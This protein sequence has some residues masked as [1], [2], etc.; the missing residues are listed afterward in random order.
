[1]GFVL[2]LL[3][4]L[5]SGVLG[6]LR[7]K[8]NYWQ[9]N[10]MKQLRA[11]FLF[12]HFVKL[13][14]LHLSELLQET[15]E[16]F[17]GSALLA[18]SYIYLRPIAVVLDLDL[19]KRILIEDC[20]K[21]VDRQNS[22]NE[23]L[24]DNLFNAQGE[25]WSKLRK[26]QAQI[27]TSGMMR[28]NMFE[29][30][31]KSANNLEERFRELVSPHGCVLDVQE[32]L[33]CY[34]MDA[35]AKCAFGSHINSLRD[36]Q[37]EFRVQAQK[38]L[39]NS[40][41]N[42]RWRL[43]KLYY[44]SILAKLKLPIQSH[45]KN[46]TE[47]FRRIVKEQME[48]RQL[49]NIKRNDYLELLVGNDLTLEQLT[50]QTFELFVSG[51]ETSSSILTCALFELAKHPAVQQKL[52]KE[53]TIILRKH[54][55][56]TYEAMLEMRY[57]EQTITET[58]RKYPALASLIRITAEEYT[59]PSAP[60]DIPLILD[61]DTIVH[62]PVHAIH[63][64]AEIYP[65]PKLFRPERFDVSNCLQRH[66]MAFLGF[67]AGPRQ[68]IGQHFGRLLIKIGLIQLLAQYQFSCVPGFPD[69]LPINKGNMILRPSQGVPLKVMRLS[70]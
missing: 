6:Y 24:T 38:I 21:F 40:D 3:T 14:S 43:F 36:D 28:K 29:T 51:Y 64:D 60:G 52:R 49:G 19:A 9:I 50:S 32:L 53:L 61:K 35:S 7:C 39:R 69:E 26:L 54:G 2:I 5:L 65:Q 68:C 31:T 25:E 46:I 37:L 20:D 16:A 23:T 42:I 18:G 8:Y 33:D 70:E 13:K 62:I 56:L 55:Q 59:L 44:W 22:C 48:L 12:G 58:L 67:G 63:Y 10:G 4:S 41:G 11:H 47:Y 27:F 30:I 17:K 57:L 1:M 45:D 15:Y 34:S 66:S